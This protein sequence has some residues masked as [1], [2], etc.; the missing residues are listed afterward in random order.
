MQFLEFRR[1]Y[2]QLSQFRGQQVD[3]MEWNGMQWNPGQV[4]V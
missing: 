2:M 4:L 3:W 1:E